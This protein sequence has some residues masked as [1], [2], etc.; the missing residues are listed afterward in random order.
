M[1]FLHG[2]STTYSLSDSLTPLV[3]IIFLL[4]IF[5]LVSS[6]F[7]KSENNLG[8]N[9]PSTKGK[10]V[11]GKKAKQWK[12]SVNPVGVIFLDQKELKFEEL[13]SILK[14]NRAKKKE[15]NI[16]LK[17][18]KKVAYG[19]VAKLIGLFKE[20]KYSKL[21]FQTINTEK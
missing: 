1:K 3:D 6:T 2:G 13:E 12:I 19:H 4:I 15:I 14:I 7:E 5:F 10:G 9:L 16:V 17:A 20:Y 21:A 8:I 18:D 11:Q